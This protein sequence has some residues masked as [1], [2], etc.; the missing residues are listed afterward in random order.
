MNFDQLLTNF[1]SPPILFFLLGLLATLVKSDLELPAPLPKILSLYLLL[2]I[3][4]KGGVEL[5]HS[6]LTVQIASTLGVAMI[7]AVVV[8][9]Y[10]YFV[11]R[12]K[13]DSANAAAIAATYGSISAV[14]FITAAAFLDATKPDNEP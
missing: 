9:V 13:L 5:A 11:L 8:P 6:G 1:L 12:L 10:T 2:A 4:F 3:G 7:A 14:T